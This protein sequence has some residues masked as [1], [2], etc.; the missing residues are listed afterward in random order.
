MCEDALAVDELSRRQPRRDAI[1]VATAG[2]VLKTTGRVPTPLYC[3][4]LYSLPVP[5]IKRTAIRK[6]RMYPSDTQLTW[7]HMARKK[8]YFST[9]RKNDINSHMEL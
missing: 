9:D 3:D 5:N 1:S 6:W 2:V 4:M 8:V 7:G